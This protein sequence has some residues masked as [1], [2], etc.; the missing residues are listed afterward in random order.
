MNHASYLALPILEQKYDNLR[1]VQTSPNGTISMT[2]IIPTCFLSHF[3][4]FSAAR[5]C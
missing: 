1:A 3:E 5:K 4:N 2:C